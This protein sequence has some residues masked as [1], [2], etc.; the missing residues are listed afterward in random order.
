M[1]Q[2]FDRENL[3]PTSISK[4]KHFAYGVLI[5]HSNYTGWKL[6]NILILEY[7]I[8]ENISKWCMASQIMQWLM[9]PK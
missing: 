9:L 1:A 8:D 6:E 2:R 5:K 3:I 7:L 4:G